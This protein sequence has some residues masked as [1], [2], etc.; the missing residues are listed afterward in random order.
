M[1]EIVWQ[2]KNVLVATKFIIAETTTFLVACE[3]ALN[4]QD[5]L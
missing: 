3:P 4:T 5:G 1:T 2:S